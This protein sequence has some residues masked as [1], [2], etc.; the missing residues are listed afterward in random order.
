[1]RLRLAPAALLLAAACASGPT[2]K[3]RQAAEIHHDLAVEALK[4]GQ[5]QSALREYDE[6]L[7]LDPG[8]PEAHLGRGLVLERAFGKVGEAEAEYR[9]A[10]AG[11][12]AYSEAHNNLGQLLA[13]TGRYD[14]AIKEFDEALSSTFYLEPFV[15]R[16]NKGQALYRMGRRADGLAELKAC[17]GIAPAYCGGRREYGRILLGEGNLTDAVVQLEAYARSCDKVPDAHYQL[18]LAHLKAGDLQAARE[19]FERCEALAGQAAVGDDCRRSLQL[20]R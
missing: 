2:P 7:K 1:M 17:V 15:A 10:I 19:R 16:C 9:Q 12:V 6:A 18:G 5:A 11:K 14:E 8:M 4:N 3:Q 20:L 13:S